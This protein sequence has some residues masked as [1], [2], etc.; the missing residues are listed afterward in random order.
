MKW[1]KNL[2]ALAAAAT[3]MSTTASAGQ[4]EHAYRRVW[5]IALTTTLVEQVSQRGI[6]IF[7]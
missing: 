2:A 6:A 5:R 4:S 1:S 3:F 7:S